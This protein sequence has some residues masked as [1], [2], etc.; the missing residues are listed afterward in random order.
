[1]PLFDLYKPL[2]S[3]P[4]SCSISCLTEAETGVNDE[5]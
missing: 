1:M 3:Q 5:Q 4:V 2:H